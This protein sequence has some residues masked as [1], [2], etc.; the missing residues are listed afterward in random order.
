MPLYY[1]LNQ[2]NTGTVTIPLEFNVNLQVPFIKKPSDYDVSVIRFSIPNYNTPLFIFKDNYYKLTLSWGAYTVSK[3]VTYIN[4]TPLPQEYIYEIQAFIQMLNG[5]IRSLVTTLN[6]LTG[7]TLPSTELPYFSYS[8]VTTLISI[9]A[10][11]NFYD[12]TLTTPIIL[13]IGET[14]LPMLQGIPI[15]SVSTKLY[16]IAFNNYNGTNL[17]PDSN[18]ETMT[19]QENTFANMVDFAAVVLTT[20]LPIQSEYIG[21]QTTLPIIQD[22]LPADLNIN[23]FHNNIVYNAIFPYR[24][25]RMISDVPF[26]SITINC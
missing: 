6:T 20:N 19:Q 11:K 3:N 14:L 1:N 26:Y 4:Q 10:N 9:T 25:V 15:I 2:T 23:T 12:S 22:Y 17:I 5:T 13:S 8:E 24:Q 21:Q 7:N 18:H 16:N